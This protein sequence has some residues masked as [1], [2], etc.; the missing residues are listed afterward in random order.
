LR[1]KE[2]HSS[3]ARVEFCFGYKLDDAFKVDVKKSS[4]RFDPGLEDGLEELISP[5]LRESNLRYRRRQAVAVSGG[6]DHSSSNKSVSDTPNT[7]KATVS[8]VDGEND[9]AVV[10]NNLGP[11]VSIS[12]QIHDNVDASQLY[13]KAVDSLP[14]GSLWAPCLNSKSS[15]NY[16][17]GLKLNKEH[18][19]Y[20]KVYSRAAS[21]NSVEGMDLLLW[22]LCAAEQ[23]NTKD[24]LSEM[25]EDIR[26]EVSSNLRKLLRPQT[27]PTDAELS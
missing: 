14:N 8:S 23:N 7:N 5:C 26:E 9:L 27:V 4:V 18:D 20:A 22:A 6:V 16:S 12:T 11:S 10:S 2:P 24:E 13:V 25:W 1:G 17:T 3:L 21:G 19:F 15:V